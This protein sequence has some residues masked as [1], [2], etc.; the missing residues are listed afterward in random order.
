MQIVT[1]TTDFGTGDYELGSMMGV[2]WSNAPQARLID[3][4]HDIERHNIRQA[5]LM[6]AH[7]TPYFPAG[8]IHV[9]VV[10]PGVGT[11]RR[12][13]AARLGDQWFVGPD[14]GLLTLML[15][16]A[17]EAGKPVKIVHTNNRQYWLSQVSNI[18]HGRDVFASVAGHLAAGIDLEKLGPE[19]QDPM[20]LD[21]PEPQPHAG[22]WSGQVMDI[23]HFGNLEI[24]IHRDQLEGLGPVKVTCGEHVI[25]G[26]VRTFGDG[27]VGELVALI[28]SSDY[29]CIGLVNGSAAAHTQA[30]IGD[31]VFVLPVQDQA[32]E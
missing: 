20:L 7:C 5:A 23:D 25:Q 26:I 3:L 15:R 17:T 6:L 32:T 11:H 18:F 14:N 22:G 9:V 16:R 13:I 1:L 4:T 31:P 8:T 21:F 28:D 19:I 2:I 12:P 24:N 29:L 10:D 27:R 30:K